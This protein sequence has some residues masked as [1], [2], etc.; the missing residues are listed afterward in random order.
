MACQNIR[1][2]PHGPTYKHGLTDAS[3]CFGYLGSARTKGPGSPFSVD[4]KAFH[5]AVCLVF[6]NLAR[7]VADIIK[8]FQ[9][10][11]WKYFMEDLAGWKTWRVR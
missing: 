7:I 6:F 1:T 11:I 3:E 5:S 10:R 9:A 2:G 4:I 8:D